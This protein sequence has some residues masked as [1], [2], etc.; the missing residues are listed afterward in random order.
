[1]SEAA[2]LLGPEGPLARGLPGFEVREG[3]IEMAAQVEEVLRDGG[4][5]FVEAGTGIGKS[6]AYLIPAI[7]HDERVVISTATRALQDQLFEKDLPQLQRLLGRRVQAVRVKGRENYLCRLEWGRLLDGE[8]ALHPRARQAD[9]RR[10]E[11]WAATTKTGDRDEIPGMRSSPGFWRGISTVAEN[12]IGRNC[13]E[14]DECYLTNL[15][16]ATRKSRILIVNHHL[17]VAD[18]L[19]RQNG[20]GEILG[21]YDRLIVDE[22][23]RLEAAATQSLS[24][25]LTSGAAE[26]LAVDLNRFW[27]KARPEGATPPAAARLKRAWKELFGELPWGAPGEAQGFDPQALSE[28]ATEAREHAEAHLAALGASVEEVAEPAS[29]RASAP[30]GAEDPAAGA[31]RL[32]VKI[33]DLQRDLEEVFGEREDVVH[34]TRVV[35]RND[36]RASPEALP[37]GRPGKRTKA[38]P[39]LYATVAP[40]HPGGQLP[41]LLF[42][43]VGSCVLTS[44][45]LSVDGGFAHAAEELG[46]PDAREAA[47]PSPFDYEDQGRLFVPRDLP[48]PQSPHFV[49]EVARR[50][51][52]LINASRGRALVLFTSWGN[53]ERVH[54]RL[55]E[56]CRY[57]VLRQEKGGAN[58]RRLDDFRRQSNAVL[59]GVRS[60]WE[61]VDLPG[62]DLTLLVIDK[63]P[64]PVPTD[65]LQQARQERAEQ[66]TGSGFAHYTVPLTTLALKQGLG[67]LIRS[68]RDQGLAAVFDSRLV[69][70]PYGR[71]ILDSLPPFRRIHDTAEAVRFLEGL[72]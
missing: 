12:C 56:T 43:E 68:H 19:V 36:G 61:G 46:V 4:S 40:V 1:M 41:G 28:A 3:Q 23:H 63:L 35:D 42:E 66:A 57:P 49:P 10:I 17:L 60:F 69:T 71:R 44:A 6:F 51:L 52:E 18:R 24:Y 33:Q 9:I 27:K 11:T 53:L 65:P 62:E 45:T 31:T 22:A 20:F 16:Q 37:L 38:N 47:I 26:R 2:D 67:R 21:D 54:R 7:L 48:P 5:L 34:W 25:T 58:Q 72:P 70:R 55:R 50:L 64:F 30:P 14:Y 32:I 15:R 8:T 39:A 29:E 59:L 13:P